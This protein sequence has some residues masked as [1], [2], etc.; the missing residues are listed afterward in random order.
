[1]PVQSAFSFNCGNLSR[2]FRDLLEDLEIALDGRF[3][4][5]PL[6]FT[7]TSSPCAAS[8]VNLPE[9]GGRDR[10]YLKLFVN[11]CDLASEL[12]FLFVQMR[13]HLETAAPDR[14]ACL[15]R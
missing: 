7:A 4:I 6:H 5:R 2:K 14:P 3:E 10:L 11:I 1:M 15:A 9:R 13:S 12:G 8:S